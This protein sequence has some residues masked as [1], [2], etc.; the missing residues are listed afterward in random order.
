MADAPA[1]AAEANVA[2]TPLPEYFT[3]MPTTWFQ[4]AEARFAAAPP[5]ANKWSKIFPFVGK[6]AAGRHG[7]FH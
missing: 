4:Q 7:Q 2:M 3:N 6:T 5:I 1:A